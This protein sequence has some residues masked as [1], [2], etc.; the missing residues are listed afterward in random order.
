[1]SEGTKKRPRYEWSQIVGTVLDH[2]V[3]S[4]ALG[5]AETELS[6][7]R[8]NKLVLGIQLELGE[9]VYPVSQLITKNGSGFENAQI[10]P[11]LP[12]ILKSFDGVVDGLAVTRWLGT[13]NRRLAGN[14]PWESLTHEA[15][16]HDV[17]TAAAAQQQAWLGE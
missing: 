4:Q 10:M 16:S 14:T 11:A 7:L 3:M 6:Q 8:T 12:N 9:W 1:M 13:P 5:V 2:A 15:W 17:L